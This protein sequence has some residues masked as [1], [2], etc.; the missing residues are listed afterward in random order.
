[1]KKGEN[2]D[3]VTLTKITAE[4]TKKSAQNRRGEAYEDDEERQQGEGVQCRQQ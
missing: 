3:E 2:V 1:M 4:H